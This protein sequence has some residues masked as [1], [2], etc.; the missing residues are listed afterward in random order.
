MKLSLKLQFTHLAVGIIPLVIVMAIGYYFSNKVL[1]K[2]IN[3]SRDDIKHE[4]ANKL[5]AVQTLKIANMQRLIQK[6]KS[7]A[8]ALSENVHVEEMFKELKMYH[9][10]IHAGKETFFNVDSP[11]YKQIY[12]KYYHFFEDCCKNYGYYDIFLICAAHGHV[13]YTKAWEKDLGTNLDSGQYNKSGLA[14]CWRKALDSAKVSIVDFEKYAPSQNAQTAFIGIPV[15]DE[16]GKVIYVLAVQMATR[17]INSI[18]QE[19]VGMGKTGESYIVGRNNGKTYLCSDRAIKDGKVGDPKSGEFINLAFD[20]KSGIAQKT[21]STG[22]KEIVAY[23]PLKIP[24]LDWVLISNIGEEEIFAAVNRMI[25]EGNQAKKQLLLIS[26]G[27]AFLAFVVICIVAHFIVRS[28]SNPVASAVS[29]LSKGSRQL[30]D[31]SSQVASSSQ[32]MSEGASEQASSLEEISSSLEEMAA[33]TKQNADSSKHAIE[34]MKTAKAIV[35]KGLEG[36]SNM[37]SAID[38]IKKSSDK[39]AKIIKTIDEIAFQ[40]NLLALNAAVEAARAGEAGKGFAVVAEEVRNLAQRSA[41][42][43]KDTSSLIENSR[44]LAD[45]GVKVS[46]ELTENFMKIVDSTEEVNALIGEISAASNEQSQ[47]I[48]EINTGVAQLNNVTQSNAANSE[49]SA[50]A[51]EELFAQAGELGKVVVS[52]SGIIDGEKNGENRARLLASSS[53]G[54]SEKSWETNN[55]PSQAPSY[56]ATQAPVPTLAQAKAKSKIDNPEKIIPLDDNDFSDF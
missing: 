50:A 35:G 40:T 27:F 29:D 15:K 21:G 12:N 33:M 46:S 2:I 25:K 7:D 47:G 9:N 13:M 39:T 18:V 20:G 6:F 23:A 10:S 11:L 22:K 30:A 43:A 52:L 55:T 26:C 24:G 41:N 3:M 31:A 5:S 54:T 38:Q 36:A 32:S 28:V 56:L 14:R 48:N 19:K 49:E 1:D 45:N 44:T 8:T 42:A 51:S 4:A 17:N 37:S 34:L 53:T 16:S